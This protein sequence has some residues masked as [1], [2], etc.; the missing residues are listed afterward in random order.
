MSDMYSL[1]SF[2]WKNHFLM[3]SFMNNIHFFIKVNWSKDNQG[4]IKVIKFN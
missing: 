1:N 3:L 2:V 4:K